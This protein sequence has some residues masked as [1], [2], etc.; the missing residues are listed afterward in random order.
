MFKCKNILIVIW[1]CFLA[2]AVHAQVTK[3]NVL[4]YELTLEPDIQTQSVK[5]SLKVQFEVEGDTKKVTFDAGTLN[6]D[7][8]SGANLLSFSKVGSELELA[9]STSNESPYEVTIEYSGNPKKGLLFNANLNQAHTVY[10]TDH[11]MVC[12]SNP[13]DRASF[14]LNLLLP[15]GMQSVA[16][17]KS[18]GIEER[19]EKTLHKW[20]Q[21]YETPSY[22][23]GFVIGSFKATAEQIGDVKLNYYSSELEPKALKKVFV[24]TPNI[25]KFFEEKSGIQYVQDSYS[26]VL[27]GDNYQEMSGLSVLSKAY[28]TFVFKDSSEIHLTSHELA[29]QWWG[30]MITCEDFGHFW[31]NEAFAVYMSSAF[32]EYKFGDKKYQS[33]ISIYKS[34]YDDIVKRGKDRSLVFKTWMPSRLN[35]NVI[36]YKGA[37]VLHLLREKVGDELFWKGIQSYS[38][39][40]FG[41]SV[42]TDDF[43]VAMENATGLNLDTFFDRWVYNKL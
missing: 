30:N 26:Q 3:L 7:K 39:K 24:E 20:H 36:Y 27:I 41:K 23:Y 31:L 34:I 21:A 38:I 13:S 43:K 17:G 6:I 10:F 29:H 42:K 22:T 35:R 15:K 25:L 12:N 2:T 11:W 9:L 14:S 4:S 19:A 5:G 16:S 1:Y 8:V 18:L 40:Y 32:S 33:D 28:P 37:Y